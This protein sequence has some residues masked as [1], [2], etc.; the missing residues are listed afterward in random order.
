MNFFEF[1]KSKLIGRDSYSVNS[2]SLDEYIEHSAACSKFHLLEISLFTAVDLIARTISKCEFVTVQNGKEIQ[3]KEYY[4]WNYK[5]NK[6]QTKAEFIIELV[7]KLILKNEVLII[8]TSDGQLL[9]ADYFSKNE[10]A[11]FD[12]IFSDVTVKNY[13][14]Q[15]TFKTS[16]VIYLRYNNSGVKNLIGE[17]CATFEEIMQTAEERYNK[18]VGHKGFL[19]ISTAATGSPEFQARYKDLINNHFKQFFSSKNAVL[20]LYEGFGYDELPP[21]VRAAANSEINDITKLKAEA[22]R[23]VGN[24]FHIPPAVISGEASMLAE[25]TTALISNAVD[26]VTNMLEQAITAARYG[27][28]NYLKSNYI[29]IDTTYARHI[30]A[31]ANANNIDKSIACGV[32]NPEKAQRYCNMLPCDEEWAKKYYITKNYE[33]AELALKGGEE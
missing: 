18:S 2:A 13:T 6:H 30:D 28:E 3:K 29:L 33:N 11:I 14:F 21:E 7:S 1:I 26:P 10:F 31:I 8:E 20:P 5:P 32:L 23:T 4:L 27:E 17:M 16:E 12:D 22:E 9:I 25:A 19:K 15:R 24:V